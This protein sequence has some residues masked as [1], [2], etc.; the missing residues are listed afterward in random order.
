M[1]EAAGAFAVLYP[2]FTYLEREGQA[3][4]LTHEARYVSVFGIKPL[5]D[6]LL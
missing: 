2:E 4:M 5:H 6:G 1:R 3:P